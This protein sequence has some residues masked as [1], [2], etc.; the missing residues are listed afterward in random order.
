MSAP[1]CDGECGGGSQHPNTGFIILFKEPKDN[2]N[3]EIAEMDLGVFL[4]FFL[5]LFLSFF[6]SL[7]F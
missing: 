1:S 7:F 6:L 4:S 5:P 2:A 3:M